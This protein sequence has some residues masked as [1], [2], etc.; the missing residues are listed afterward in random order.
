MIG[1]LESAVLRVVWRLRSTTVRDVWLHLGGKRKVAYTTIMTTMDRLYQ[2]G[3]LTRQM[4]GK[5]YHYSPRVTREDFARKWIRN[6]WKSLTG[7]VGEPSVSFL[8]QAI[9]EEDLAQFEQ[10]AREVDK[11]KRT[12]AAARRKS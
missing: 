1:E 10:L 9:R 3:L 11:A 12:D 4:E 7:A 8:V 2:K 5:A 6:L